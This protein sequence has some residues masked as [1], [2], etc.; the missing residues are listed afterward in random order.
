MASFE[1]QF[2]KVLKLEGGYQADPNDSVNFC[3]GVLAGTKYGVSAQGYEAYFGKCPSPDTMQNLTIDTAKQ[4]AKGNYWDKIDGDEISN[5]SVANLM[6]D[7]IWGSGQSQLSNIKAVANITNGTR[8]LVENDNVITKNE[9][10][11][12]NSLDQQKFFDNLKTFRIGFFN[13]L[14]QENPDRYGRYLQGWLNRINK[15]SFVS[16]QKKK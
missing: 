11:I 15:Y 13:K 2:P 10:D 12:I 6:F 1:T 8:V 5:Q 7:F 9:A 14:A 16:D 4:I 3:G